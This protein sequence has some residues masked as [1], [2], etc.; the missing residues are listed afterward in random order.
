[1]RW[2]THAS[3]RVEFVVIGETIF[4]QY[5]EDGQATLATKRMRMRVE[6]AG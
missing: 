2:N 4:R 5:F 1:L 3:S 6:T